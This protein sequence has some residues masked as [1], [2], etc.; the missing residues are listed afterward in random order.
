MKFLYNQ[1]G[2]TSNNSAKFHPNPTYSNQD[3][4]KKMFTFFKAGKFTQF[5][6]DLDFK[7]VLFEISDTEINKM[8][9][10][11]CGLTRPYCIP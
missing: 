5:T 9:T 7:L 3:I 2:Q 8:I 6:Q 10:T 1:S 4:K 11:Q